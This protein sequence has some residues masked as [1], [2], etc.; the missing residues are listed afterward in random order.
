M[1]SNLSRRELFRLL[2]T[3]A[4]L[5]GVAGTDVLAAPEPTSAVP[6]KTIGRGASHT[7][8]VVADPAKLPGPITRD[9]ALHHDITLNALEVVGRSSRAQ[10]TTT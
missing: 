4:A 10:P 9:H 8:R 3:G 1:K 7:S 5:L 6:P 2:G